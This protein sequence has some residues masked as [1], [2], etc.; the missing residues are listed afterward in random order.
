MS[1]KK[2]DRKFEVYVKKLMLRWIDTHSIG[3]LQL[4]VNHQLLERLK[5]EATK[6]IVCTILA[7]QL[8]QLQG[9]HLSD[10]L[11]MPTVFHMVDLCE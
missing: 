11:R 6:L 3:V 8:P 10:A 1:R 2:Y 7:D 5:E 4:R 9:I